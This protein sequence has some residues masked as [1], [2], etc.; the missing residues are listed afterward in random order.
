[1]PNSQVV[2]WAGDMQIKLYHRKNS[3]SSRSTR[4]KK[5][6]SATAHTIILHFFRIAESTKA[7]LL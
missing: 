2:M 7:C 3:F 1:M 6:E 4:C 5:V